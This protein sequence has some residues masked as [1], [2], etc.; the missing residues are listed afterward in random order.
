MYTILSPLIL[1]G[2]EYAADYASVQL[3]VLVDTCKDQ[4]SPEKDIMVEVTTVTGACCRRTGAYAFDQAIMPGEVG[5]E[6]TT[7]IRPRSI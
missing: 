5:Q 1:Q 2:Q 6:P 3:Q 7:V 4:I